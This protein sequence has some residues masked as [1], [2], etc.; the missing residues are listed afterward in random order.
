MHVQRDMQ[1]GQRVTSTTC[2]GP[3]CAGM[4]PSLMVIGDQEVALQRAPLDVHGAGVNIDIVDQSSPC[5]SARGQGG[6]LRDAKGAGASQ[7]Q[8]QR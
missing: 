4:K 5:W 2:T 1:P 3:A 6:W 8:R 7:D